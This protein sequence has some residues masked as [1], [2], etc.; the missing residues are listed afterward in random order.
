MVSRSE[1]QTGV[2]R[3]RFTDSAASPTLAMEDFGTVDSDVGR[4]QGVSA[5]LQT[6]RCIDGYLCFLLKRN[7][8]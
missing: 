3:N 5:V 6:Y 4:H 8:C 1:Q 7:I 2:Q